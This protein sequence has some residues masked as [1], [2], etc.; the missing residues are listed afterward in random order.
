MESNALET[1]N[2]KFLAKEKYSDQ[3]LSRQHLGR[4][5]NSAW[6]LNKL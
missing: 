4:G 5:S 3:Q 1:L 2:A 6:F